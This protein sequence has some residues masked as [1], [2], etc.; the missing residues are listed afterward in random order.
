M[1]PAD[2]AAFLASFAVARSTAEFDVSEFGFSFT[3]NADVSSD[4]GFAEMGPNATARPRHRAHG[5]RARHE[6]QQRWADRFR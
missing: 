2:P 4:R 5:R 1:A 6:A 3:S